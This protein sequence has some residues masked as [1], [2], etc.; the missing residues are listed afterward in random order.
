MVA[1]RLLP[2]APS[3]LLTASMVRSRAL[4]RGRC[5][6]DT[7]GLGQRYHD[8]RATRARRLVE[9][10]RVGRVRRDAHNGVVDRASIR[11]PPVVASSTV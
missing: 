5:R 8:G 3:H 11:S 2:P 7:R 9:R 10:N 4:D 6:E 1:R